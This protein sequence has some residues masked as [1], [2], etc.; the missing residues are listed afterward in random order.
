MG[1]L[2]SS[3]ALSPKSHRQRT[4][5]ID[6]SV[7]TTLLSILVICFGAKSKAA[8]GEE[9][10]LIRLLKTVSIL[11]PMGETTERLTE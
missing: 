6:S 1:F 5:L 11:H 10:I 3:W 7:K 9:Y 4:A 8:S 2:S